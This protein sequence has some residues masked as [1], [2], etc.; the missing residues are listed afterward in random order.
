M[1][2][3]LA[4]VLFLF[5]TIN[6]ANGKTASYEPPVFTDQT[7]IEKIQKVLPAINKMYQDHARKNHFPGYVFGVVVDGRLIYVGQGGYLDIDRKTPAS[8]HSLFRIASMTKSLT[9][10]AILQLRDQG[11]LNLDD[12]VYQYIPEIKGQ[13]LTQDAAEI[14]IR[15]LLTH[16]AGFPEDNPWGDRQLAVSDQ[17]LLAHIKSGIAFSNTNG[18]S[19]EYSNMAFAMLGY[20]IEKVSGMPYQEYIAK[21]IWQ[22]LEMKETAWEYTQVPENTYAHGYRWLENHWQ[23]EALLH[24]GSY[25]SMGGMMTSMES[26]SRYVALHMS[27]WPARNDAEAG[28]L[29]R[30]SIREMHQPWRFSDV[31]QFKLSNSS[32]CDVVNAYGYGLVWL[33]DCEGKSIYWSHGWFAGVW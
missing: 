12:P 33:R 20:I 23:N 26:F 29:K 17:D 32:K 22:P 5:T 1:R 16:S 18:T 25:A 6:Y 24:D 14:T 15:Q 7:R 3:I 2:L 4:A 8:S 10:M 13:H 9:A 27:A 28:P 30:S 21:N 11:K 31:T 19:Y